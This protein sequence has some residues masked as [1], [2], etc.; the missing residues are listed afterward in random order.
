MKKIGI[1]GL[2]VVGNGILNYYNSLPKYTIYKYDKYKNIGEIEDIINSE[3]IFLCLP[4]LFDKETKT[5]DT[6]EIQNI[7]EYLNNKKYNGILLLKSTVTPGTTKNLMLKYNLNIIHNPEFLSQKTANEDFKNQIQIILGGNKEKT[8]II[9]KF[10]E[11]DFKNVKITEMTSDESELVKLSLNN[12]YSVK[13]QF[14]TE[15]YLLCNNLNNNNYDVDFIKIRD[16]MLLNK[17]INPNHTQIPGHDGKLSY[18]GMCFPKD[19]NA[20]LN[21]MKEHTEYYS[22]LEAT[23]TERNKLRND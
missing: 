17:W 10:Y 1:V 14:F 8:N 20:L 18:G 5:Y 2:G 15:L 16:A 22:I 12:F 4:T 21:F 3:V 7:C 9:K 6:N 13:I 23:V 11:N 19:T